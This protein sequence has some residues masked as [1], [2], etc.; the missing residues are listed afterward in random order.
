M[1]CSI[2]TTEDA[3]ASC[4][5]CGRGLCSQC[6]DLHE[7]PTCLKCMQKKQQDIAEHN[8]KAME[9]KCRESTSKSTRAIISILWHAL[10]LTLGTVYLVQGAMQ[11]H[12][13]AD[14]LWGVVPIWGIS[15]LPWAL[16]TGLFK[17]DDSV[18]E[19]VRRGVEASVDPGTSLL[20]G[21]IGFGFKVFFAFLLGA[22]ASPIIFIYN[23]FKYQSNK[24]EARNAA[25]Q[26]RQMQQ[27]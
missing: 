19:Q 14:I 25:N 15:G 21:M 6:A 4:K 5:T 24:T 10:F 16:S 2:H 18:E 13:M 27:E 11:G 7:E 22:I 20:A 1:K 8:K 12:A 3:V 26:L 23:I 9:E 17:K